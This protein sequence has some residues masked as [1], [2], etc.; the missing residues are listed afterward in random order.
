[1]LCKTWDKFSTDTIH[2]YIKQ[3]LPS[4]RQYTLP[5]GPQVA[6]ILIDY[7]R[8]NG[9]DIIIITISERLINVQDVARYND[10]LQYR[11]LLPYESYGSDITSHSNNGRW[12]TCQDYYAYTLQVTITYTSIFKKAC[13]SRYNLGFSFF[14][15][16]CFFKIRHHSTLLKNIN[17]KFILAKTK[18]LF[19]SGSQICAQSVSIFLYRGLLLQQY[20]V[21]KQY[22]VDNFVKI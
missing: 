11:L 4:L 2:L 14:F 12:V 3:Q 18:E 16:S 10:P 21:D 1:M 22:V 13:D 9:W 15:F 7:E 8:A 5:I 20:V 17:N 19:F 6:A